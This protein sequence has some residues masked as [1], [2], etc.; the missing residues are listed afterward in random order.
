MRAA[1]VGIRLMHVHSF[2]HV[3]SPATKRELGRYAQWSTEF[4]AQNNHVEPVLGKLTSEGS[5][6]L[7]IVFRPAKQKPSVARVIFKDTGDLPAGLLQTAMY[8]VAIGM[9]YAEPQFR[10]LLD[11]T[12]RPLYDAKGMIRVAFPKIETEP[13]KDVTGIIVTVQ[14]EPGAGY[15]LGKVSIQV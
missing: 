7:M 1:M 8:G 3:S 11:T 9:V 4:L 13:A 6:D 5:P 15:K 14:V 12:I 10:L 2:Y